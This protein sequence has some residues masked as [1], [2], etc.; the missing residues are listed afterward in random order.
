MNLNCIIMIK[1]IEEKKYSIRKGHTNH[2]IDQ[3]RKMYLPYLILKLSKM[4]YRQIFNYSSTR[5]E[6]VF[7][8]LDDSI[9]AS[10]S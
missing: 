2:K 7:A 6:Y 5:R 1:S 9:L 8:L 3:R 4:K 10:H